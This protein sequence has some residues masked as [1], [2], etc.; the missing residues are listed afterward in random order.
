MASAITSVEDHAE[1]HRRHYRP[2]QPRY[3]G[4]ALRDIRRQLEDAA[5]AP[6]AKSAA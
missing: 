2:Y 3:D 1:L 6:A 4:S 5:D